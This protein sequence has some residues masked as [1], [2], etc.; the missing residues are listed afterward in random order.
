MNEL[1]QRIIDNIRA[2]ARNLLK[3]G[4]P[5]P[6]RD[7]RWDDLKAKILIEERELYEKEIE[8][9]HMAD[10]ETMNTRL[11]KAYDQANN[12]M[13]YEEWLEKAKQIYK[14][15]GSIVTSLASGPDHLKT[16][17]T[18]SHWQAQKKVLQLIY[19]LYY[20]HFIRENGTK[21]FRYDPNK[22]SK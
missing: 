17:D 19:W 6:D 9:K 7:P 3:R 10:Y 2:E 18:G 12:G 13:G 4:I 22:E 15:N 14:I 20:E 21:D 16:W 11:K 8:A 1:Q 5:M